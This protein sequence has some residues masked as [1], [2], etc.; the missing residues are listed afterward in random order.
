MSRT[1][2]IFKKQ[3]AALQISRAPA[4]G[5]H[6]ELKAS[7]ADTHTCTLV[8]TKGLALLGWSGEAVAGLWRSHLER[9]GSKDKMFGP[10][11]LATLLYV[12]LVSDVSSLA[13]HGCCIG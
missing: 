2:E 6:T 12:R 10:R 3:I 4:S 1:I 8:R 11:Q 7:S 13:S 9:N 5:S